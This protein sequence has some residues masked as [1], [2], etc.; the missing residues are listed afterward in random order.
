M[1]YYHSLLD[2]AQLSEESGLGN[3]VSRPELQADRESMVCQ[4]GGLVSNASDHPVQVREI[5]NSELHSKRTF[6]IVKQMTNYT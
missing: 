6:K 3:Q 5:S 4:R 2:D 1:N